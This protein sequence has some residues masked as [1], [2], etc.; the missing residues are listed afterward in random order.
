MYFSAHLPCCAYPVVLLFFFTLTLLC[1]Y[2][3]AHLPCCSYPAVLLFFFTLTL[4][5][6]YFS[7]HLPCCTLIFLRTW[8]A[9]GICDRRHWP[10]DV[11]TYLQVL[12]VCGYGV[13]KAVYVNFEGVSAG[14]G[15]IFEF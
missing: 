11:I 10:P 9:T 14:F 5:C 1:P 3:S 7:T 13:D 12:D 15:R 6:P 2:F 4:L 8:H